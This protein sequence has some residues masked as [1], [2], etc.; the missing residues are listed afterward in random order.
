MSSSPLALFELLLDEADERADKIF[1]I[2]ADS[3]GS[4]VLQQLGL[5]ALPGLGVRIK[6]AS[7]SKKPGLQCLKMK[8]KGFSFCA[9]DCQVL[10]GGFEVQEGQCQSSTLCSATARNQSLS[11]HSWLEQWE[12]MLP[13]GFRCI[14]GAGVGV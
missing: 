13:E 5:P 1:T 4:A 10:P 3:L 9:G 6:A 14:Q 12:G 8:N 2:Q 11:H 7:V